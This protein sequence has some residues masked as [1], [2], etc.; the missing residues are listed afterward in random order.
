MRTGR[1]VKPLILS[2]EDRGKLELL[3]RQPKTDQRTAQRA[4]IV[5][6]CAAGQTNQAVAARL[7]LT[8]QTVG[9][10]RERFRQG[11]LVEIGLRNRK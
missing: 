11:A 3:A 5:L 6:E 1:P 2:E 10:W 8:T 9:T 4:R 7:G